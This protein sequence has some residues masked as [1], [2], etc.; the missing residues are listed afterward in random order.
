MEL[1][2]AE[3]C[4]SKET[5]KQFTLLQYNTFEWWRKLLL[6]VVSAALILFG[7]FYAPSFGSPLLTI[8][9]IFIGC[10]LFTNLDARANTGADQV[11]VA[12]HG[13]FPTLRYSFSDSGFTDGEGR[14]T[15]PY[16]QLYR[17]ME[18]GQYLV[19]F[20]SKASGYMFRK[21]SVQG[22]DGINGLMNLLSQKSGLAWKRPFSLLSFG[23][24]DLLSRR[25]K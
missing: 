20:T 1:Y 21:D 9:C 7:I 22:E 19:L 13:Q 23:L 12:M 5:L 15:V 25:K 16:D 14:P 18:D 6:I 2:S 3:I 8:L 4:H 11:V 17:L 10:I 24:W